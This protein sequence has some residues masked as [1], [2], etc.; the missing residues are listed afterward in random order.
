M[1]IPALSVNPCRVHAY[2]AQLVEHV[3]GKDEVT[4]SSPVVGS[5][6]VDGEVITLPRSVARA[7]FVGTSGAFYCAFLKETAIY[8][9]AEVRA[10]QA[11]Y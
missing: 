1:V 8:G 6:C 7:D 3:F 10:H 4:G 2:V 11:A 5:R 9:E